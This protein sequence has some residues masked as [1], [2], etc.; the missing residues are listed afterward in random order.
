MAR[1][2]RFRLPPWARKCIIIIEVSVTPIMVF[3]LVRTLLIPTTFDILL[4]GLLIGLVIA[5]YL[6]WI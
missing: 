6:E 5:F 1:F 4:T 2:Y 3:Q